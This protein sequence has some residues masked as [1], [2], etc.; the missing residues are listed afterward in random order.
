MLDTWF[1]P[2][3]LAIV[4]MGTLIATFLR[5][6]AADVRIA[7]SAAYGLLHKPFDI[8]QAKAALAIQ[9]REIADDGFLRAEPHHFGDN[10]FDILSDL[11]ISQRSIQSLHTEHLKFKDA[12][13][14]AAETA[15]SVFDRAA[16]LAPILGLA[17]TLT[18]LAQAQGSTV[19]ETDIVAAVS[20]AV[21]TTLYGLVAAN[22]IFAPLGSAIARQSHREEIDRQNV[23][24]WLAEGIRRTSG[25]DAEATERR[26]AA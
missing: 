16:E 19:A 14:K 26:A 22:A 24:E 9:I 23:L 20:M 25:S 13:L 2:L 6:G 15:V 18:A 5:C 7:I 17:G 21:I 1:D 12:R 4:L 10:E 11:I 8:A 3:A